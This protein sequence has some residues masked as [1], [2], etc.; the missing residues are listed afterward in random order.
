VFAIYVVLTCVF[1][2]VTV[3]YQ[4]VVEVTLLIL[5]IGGLEAVFL[6]SS[7][8]LV[9]RMGSPRRLAVTADVGHPFTS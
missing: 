6:Y 3:A 9:S 2:I 5:F 4:G 7:E 1:Y 8:H